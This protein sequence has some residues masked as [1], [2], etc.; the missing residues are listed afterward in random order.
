MTL[1]FLELPRHPITLGMRIDVENLSLSGQERVTVN[2]AIKPIKG[3]GL[4]ESLV[5]FLL[6]PLRAHCYC[7]YFSST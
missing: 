7:I 5:I 3:S 4:W 6:F 2:G 1:V